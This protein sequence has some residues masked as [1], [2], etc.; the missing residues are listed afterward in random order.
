MNKKKRQIIQLVSGI[1]ILIASTINLLS[2][3]FDIPPLF[4]VVDFVFMFIGTV[5]LVIVIINIKK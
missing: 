4:F 2:N 1:C 5:L 3:F